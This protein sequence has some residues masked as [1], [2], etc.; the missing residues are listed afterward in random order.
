MWWQA[1][2]ALRLLGGIALDNPGAQALGRAAQKRRLAL[3]AILA[4]PPGTAVSRERLVGL[5][6]PEVPHAEA[7][8]R[9]VVAL[10]DLRRALGEDAILTSPLD[11]TLAP[12]AIRVDV[13]AF[14]DAIRRG[15]WERAVALYSGPFLDGVYLVPTAAFEQWVEERRAALE[16]EYAHA[17]EQVAAER[18]GRADRAG[19]IEAW[20]RL[21]ALDPYSGR[22][23]AGLMRALDAAGDR[24]AAIRQ[25]V[26]HAELLR[27]ELETEPDPAVETLASELRHRHPATADGDAGATSSGPAEAAPAAKV[28]VRAS[29]GPVRRGEGS[30]R[31]AQDVA[32]AGRAWRRPAALAILA[33]ATVVTVATAGVARMRTSPRPAHALTALAVGEGHMRAGRFDEAVDVLAR[34]VAD[35]STLARAHH[36]LALATMWADRPGSFMETHL[37]H[38]TRQRDRLTPLE[39]VV[40]QALVAWRV[41]HANRA[42]A[43]YRRA[44]TMDSTSVEAWHQLG[45][46]LFHYNPT[47]GRRVA[48]ARAV[49]E[50]VLALEPS[51][52]GA[53]WHLAQLAALEGSRSDVAKYTDAILAL[54][55]DA[56]RAL[57]VRLFRAAALAN[58]EHLETLMHQLRNADES[59][60][61][62]MGWRLAVFARD[63]DT[64]ARVFTLLT[65]EARPPYVRRFGHGQL[66]HLDLALGRV[67]DAL[68]R[69]REFPDAVPHASAL[70]LVAAAGVPLDRATLGELRDALALQVESTHSGPR[71]VNALLANA[72]ASLAFADLLLGDAAAAID[73]ADEIER[74]ADSVRGADADLASRVRARAA[75]V[76]ALHSWMEGRPRD[77]LAW[78]DRQQPEHGFV[79]TAFDVASAQSFE[80]YLRAEALLA[81][82]NMAEADAWLEGLG[83][84]VTGDL[85]FLGPALDRRVRIAA[86]RGDT[87]AVRSLQSRFAALRD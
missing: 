83:E 9:L 41:G 70:L 13:V 74:L 80:R 8:H 51:H 79:D 24:T 57:E 18:G 64:A 68:R 82:G 78:L 85:I 32:P 49:F 42:E 28:A 20:R 16:R 6:W 54:T 71:Q 37:E 33:V 61:F 84:N 62:G 76:R 67:A 11:A 66:L 4:T 5:L 73:T 38:A 17:L 29:T 75:S 44:L 36:A 69:V 56:P 15:D 22:F 55:P 14:R 21:V 53:L 59:L 34:A 35:D 86:S 25:A 81:L 47:R 12:A 77:A 63:L 30:T 46:T 27:A 52:F 43:L 31:S 2:L 40:H 10:Y 45:E 48:E 7:R 50:R 60:L 65:D 3:L 58:E 87:A 1:M 23:V 19:Q 39:G 72:L 26:A